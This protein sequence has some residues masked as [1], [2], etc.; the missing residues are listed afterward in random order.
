MIHDFLVIYCRIFTYIER[1]CAEHVY[2]YHRCM[3]RDTVEYI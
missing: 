3:I 1:V 2:K